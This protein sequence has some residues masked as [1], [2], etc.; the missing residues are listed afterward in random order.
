[1]PF[2][3][4]CGTPVLSTGDECARCAAAPTSAPAAE[5]RFRF[6]GAGGTLLKIYLVTFL[7]TLATLG[8]YYFWGKTRIRKY[9]AGSIEFAGDRLAYHG[10]G[11]ELLRGFAV[12]VAVFGALL[13][14]M[15]LWPVLFPDEPKAA[16]AGVAVFYIAL[17]LLIPASIVGAWRYRL[18]RTS[19]REIRF[20]FDGGRLEFLKIYF[21]GLALTVLTLSL[22]APFW[23]VRM[24]RFLVANARLGSAPFGFD[25]NGR[26]LF[27]TWVVA[28]L[29]ALPTFTLS[30]YWYQVRQ[31][32][33]FFNR[34]TIGNARFALDLRASEFFGVFLGS[35][36]LTVFTL[37]IGFPW[38]QCM[39]LRF[40]TD[41]LTLCGELPAAGQRLSGASA[42][43]EEL[44]DV[45]DAGG[46]DLS[47][48][49]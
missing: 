33:Y 10:T 6:H 18:S 29:L 40:F 9:L 36:V 42:T 14:Q 28:L 39:L 25:G 17:M 30:L 19:W 38:A 1:M 49:L 46:V 16:G 37:G 27:K 47:L 41:R 20:G 15:L 31:A 34:T 3:P 7:L 35:Y 4:R 45:V 43:G 13:G 26:D 44:S 5:H 23:A 24:H 22:Y 2:C 48:G 32:N 21:G 12:A 8:L 11:G